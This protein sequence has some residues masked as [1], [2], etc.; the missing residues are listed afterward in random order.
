MTNLQTDQ[1][2]HWVIEMAGNDWNL[3]LS[4]KKNYNSMFC[5][6][7]MIK[8][9]QKVNIGLLTN[10][11]TDQPMV[12]ITKNWVHPSKNFIV[13]HHCILLHLFEIIC[14]QKLCFHYYIW[15]K[16]IKNIWFCR[17]W[18]FFGPSGM[19]IMTKWALIWL[20]GHVFEC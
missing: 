3:V 2:T 11:Q 15:G 9:P 5:V 14:S 1:P 4:I 19:L 13:S 7:K 17:F 6:S 12:R 8:N 10:Q 16:N 20:S 18:S